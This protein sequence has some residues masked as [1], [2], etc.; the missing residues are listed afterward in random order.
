ME[1]LDSTRILFPLRQSNEIAQS[2]SGCLVPEEIARRVTDGLMEKFSFAF[3]R[4]WLLEM[5]QSMLRLVASSGLHTRLDGAFSRV[6]LGAYKVGKIAQN[7]VA[8]LSN[9]LPEEPWVGN[10][11]WAIANQIYG[12]AGYPLMVQERVIGVLAIFSQST[13]EPEFLEVLQTLCT[14]VAIALDTALQYQQEK[15]LTPLATHFPPFTHFSLSDQLVVL[16]KSARLTLVGTERSLTPLITY[17]F[18]SVAEL[19][20]KMGCTYGRLTYTETAAVLEATVPL[21]S[22]QDSPQWI[23]WEQCCSMV[24]YLGGTLQT[25]SSANQQ[26]LQVMLRIS[27]A[28]S[29]DHP[30]VRVKCQSPVLQ[31]AFSQLCGLAGFWVSQEPDADL[32]LLTDDVT[33]IQS[34]KRV[35][36]IQQ[37]TYPLPKNVRATVNLHITLQDLK[38]TITALQEQCCEENSMSEPAL[39]LSE[40]ELEILRLLTQGHRDRDIADQLIISESTVKFHINNVLSKLKARTRYQAIYQ[41]IVQGWL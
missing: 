34:A 28:D 1:L 31:L 25:Q 15:R 20:D 13:L 27:Y 18:L 39:L 21:S 3:T 40:R 32:P 8:F 26:A 24:T 22:I 9:N 33:Q 30:A 17:V 36:W 12:F 11:E 6:K 10:R 7:R 19:L 2:F 4:L 16:L 35:I 38:Q 41:A 5:D 14:I 23:K 37:N 29:P